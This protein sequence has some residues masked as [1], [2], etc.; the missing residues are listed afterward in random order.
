[1][2]KHITTIIA[3]FMISACAT[4]ASNKTVSID[5]MFSDYND[6]TVPGAALLVMRN[7]RV[8]TKRG[9]GTADFTNNIAVNAD[10]NFRLAS[11]SKQF[12]ALAVLQLVEKGDISLSSRLNQFFPTFPKW[13]EHITIKDML[14]H[15]SGIVDYESLVPESF[16]GQVVDADVFNLL[17]DQDEI[18]FP[19]GLKYQ[20]SNSAYALLALIVERVSGFRF[21]DYLAQNIFVPLGMNDTV[22]LDHSRHRVANRAYGYALAEDGS[23]ELADQSKFSAVLGDGGIY[24]NLNDLELWINALRGGQ[25]LNEP[26]QSEWLKDQKNNAGEDINYGYGWRLEEI[27][28]IRATYHTGISRGFRNVLYRVPD[29]ELTVVILTNRTTDGPF[30]PLQMARMIVEMEL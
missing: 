20:Y 24:S 3:A 26:L 17:E 23:V 13:S 7:G 25:L 8:I 16:V 14:R 19:A 22:A 4:S 11:V 27:N 9:F 6:S 28:N 10:T 21:S 1:M 18:Y 30:T 12:T 2:F 5:E 15:T 29:R